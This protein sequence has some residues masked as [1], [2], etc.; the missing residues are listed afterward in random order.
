MG[1]LVSFVHKRG[2]RCHERARGGSADLAL[3]L[4]CCLCLHSP[5]LCPRG[6]NNAWRFRRGG[7]KRPRPGISG[8]APLPNP[9]TPM[10]QKA[11]T[12]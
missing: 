3:G 6:G 10:E 11:A 8:R 7:G 2:G 4:V 5:A 1:A 9:P 12:A